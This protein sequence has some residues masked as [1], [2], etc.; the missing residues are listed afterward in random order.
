MIDI[1]TRSQLGLET[2]RRA[3]SRREFL[4]RAAGRYRSSDHGTA[5]QRRRG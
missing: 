3:L 5:R 4:G 2:A 1:D